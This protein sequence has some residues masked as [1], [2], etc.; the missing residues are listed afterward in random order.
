MEKAFIGVNFPNLLSVA[1]MVGVVFALYC[2]LRKYAF[3]TSNVEQ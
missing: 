1:I 3:P 2:G